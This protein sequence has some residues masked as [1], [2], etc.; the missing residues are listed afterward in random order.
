MEEMKKFSWNCFLIKLNSTAMWAWCVSNAITF[1]L[2]WKNGDKSWINT[3]VI[4]NIII[5]VLF[6]GGKILIDALATMV[7]K[8]NLNVGVGLGGSR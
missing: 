3:M 8:G 1:I 5:T 7:S 4:G 2:C 6:V